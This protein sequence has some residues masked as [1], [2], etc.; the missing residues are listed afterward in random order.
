MVIIVGVRATTYIPS[1]TLL[2]ENLK[3]PKL[4]IKQACI[5]INNIAI[6]HAISILLHK[7][8]LKNNQPLP[9]LHNLP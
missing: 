4:A 2:N 3:I 5:N 9:N 7:S 1:M 6:H 8:R